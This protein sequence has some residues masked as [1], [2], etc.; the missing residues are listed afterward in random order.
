M[1]TNYLRIFCYENNG[2]Y[3]QNDTTS[4][5]LDTP[6]SIL[7]IKA[8]ANNK[9]IIQISFTLPLQITRAALRPRHIAGLVL[10][11]SRRHTG[12]LQGIH[13]VPQVDKNCPFL[14]EYSNIF[15]RA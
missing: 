1:V 6:A 2:S 10:P 8:A 4:Q 7:V 13:S 15:Q 3:H 14:K 9:Q 5:I 11:G 12:R